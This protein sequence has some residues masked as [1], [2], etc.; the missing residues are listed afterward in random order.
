LSV[1]PAVELATLA[2]DGALAVIAPHPDDE[3]LGCGG[4]IATAVDAG[5]DVVVVVV[6]DG[7]ASHPTSTR[8]SRADLV[9][10]RDQELRQGLSSLGLDPRKLRTLGIPDGG[11]EMIGET[12]LAE[13]LGEALAGSTVRSLFATSVEDPHPDHRAVCR[14]ATTLAQRLD[15]ALWTYPVR[16]HVI[17]DHLSRP[18]ALVRLA[19]GPVLGRKQAAI[20]CHASQLGG[21]VDDDLAG[22]TLTP[23]DL[24]LH[25]APYEV[26]RRSA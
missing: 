9:R 23:D 13:R 7:G 25:T 10:V 19:I 12:V 20:A 15:A 16:A 14:A 3:T 26:F 24:S 18:Q 1:P 17:A 5:R 8:L 11:V 4:L 21:L 6:T 2:P 22:F